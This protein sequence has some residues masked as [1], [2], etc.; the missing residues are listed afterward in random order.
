[1][2]YKWVTVGSSGKCASVGI[3]VFGFEKGVLY[4][5]TRPSWYNNNNNNN[6]NISY[7]I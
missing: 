6:N 3:A 7:N 2:F 1:M 5:A 4:G